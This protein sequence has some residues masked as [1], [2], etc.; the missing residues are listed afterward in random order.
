MFGIPVRGTH[1]HSWVMSFDDELEAF[2][3]YARAMPNNC[4]FLVDTYD[5]VEGVKRAIEAGKWLRTTGHKLAGIRLDSGDLAYLSREARRLLDEAGFPDAVI[6]ASNDLDEKIIHSLK[7]QGA[8]IG[9]WGVGTKLVTGNEEPALGGV[10]KL[11]AVRIPGGEWKYKVKISEQSEKTSNPG[12]LQVRRYGTE[13]ED[14]ADVIYDIHTDVSQGCTMIDPMDLTRR[15]RIPAD[16]PHTDLLV[17]IFRKGKRVYDSPPLDEMRELAR[18]HLE[19][20]HP[21]I[22]RVVH[23]HRYPVGLE[24]SLFDLKTELVLR[25]RKL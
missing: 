10:Y 21:G 17:P 25:A 3:A 4:V 1:A 11:T 8:R 23:P 7:E 14:Q 5:T 22:K 16:M 20:F 12:I 15:K 19:R 24:K 18:K 13:S 9:L 2:Q 6:V